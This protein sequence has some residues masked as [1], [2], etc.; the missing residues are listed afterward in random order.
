MRIGTLLL[1]AL[2]P[3]LAGCGH[4]PFPVLDS[5][6]DALQGK[7]IKTVSDVLGNPDQVSQA[8][9]ETSYQ[10]SL[11]KNFGAVYDAVSARCDIAVFTGKNGLITHYTYSGNNIGCSRYAIKLD[12]SYHFAQGILD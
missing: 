6:L 4:T 12:K 3:L 9:D 7:P 8:G 2:I 5:K 11:T 1:T 10:W